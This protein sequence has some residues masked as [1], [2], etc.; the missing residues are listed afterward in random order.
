MVTTKGQPLDETAMKEEYDIDIDNGEEFMPAGA[1]FTGGVEVAAA[2]D[3]ASTGA[4]GTAANV[5]G[6][7]GGGLANRYRSF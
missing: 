4:G 5:V 3:V 6:A 2:R 1:A 7:N